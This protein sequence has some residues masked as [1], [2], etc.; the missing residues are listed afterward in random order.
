VVEGSARGF[1]EQS[2]AHGGGVRLDCSAS[3]CHSEKV[4]G[5][6]KRSWLGSLPCGEASVAAARVEG[7]AER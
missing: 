2:R 6:G 7:A 3:N 5:R 4:W 1:D